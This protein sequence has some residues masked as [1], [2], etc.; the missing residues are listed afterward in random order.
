MFRRPDPA[1]GDAAYTRPLPF[2]RGGS[3][4]R[5]EVFSPKL[6]RRMSLSSYETWQIWLALEANPAVSTFCERPTFVEGIRGA[7][8]D[9]WVGLPDRPEGEFWL[10][11]RV[12]GASD[13]PDTPPPAALEE[14]VVPDRLHKLPVRRIRAVDLRSWSVPVANWARIVP[15]LVTWRRFADPLLAQSIVVYLGR[16]TSLQDVL[17]HFADHD[18]S[19]VEAALY[20]L[21]AAGRVES[22][23]LARAPISGATRFRRA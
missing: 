3:R 21:V 1:S 8:I 5:I 13:V 9:F 11:D 14:T 15:H 19:S 7:V 20:A 23:D 18:A 6:G 12:A 10:L 2:T 17:D 4:R 22:P 16:F